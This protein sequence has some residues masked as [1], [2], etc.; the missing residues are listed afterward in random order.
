VPCFAPLPSSVKAR[1]LTEL[2]LVKY[3]NAK[4]WP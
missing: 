3:D 4:V 1:V 2:K